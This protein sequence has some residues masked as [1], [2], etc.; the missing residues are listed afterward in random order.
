MSCGQGVAGKPA[1]LRN[2]LTFGRI[3]GNVNLTGN[4]VCQKP[5]FDD[6]SPVVDQFVDV[7]HGAGSNPKAGFF[8]RFAFGGFAQF[9]AAL[10][11]AAGT[12]PEV[13][14]ARSIVS[15]EQDMIVS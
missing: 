6:P 9:F 5:E 15:D 7:G 1:S 2:R 8:M 10:D 13:M 14:L 11:A 3:G 12:C 4:I